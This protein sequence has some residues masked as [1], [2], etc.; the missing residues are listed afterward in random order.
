MNLSEIGE[1]AIKFLLE[2]PGRYSYARLN[3]YV[4]MPNHV[5]MIMVI[6]K[7]HDYLD[8]ADAKNRDAINRVSR[9]RS[10]LFTPAWN[11]TPGKV[12]L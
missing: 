2:I 3:E 7:G 5:H 1:I 11:F 6:D 4:I 8:D 10:E 9:I 12:S